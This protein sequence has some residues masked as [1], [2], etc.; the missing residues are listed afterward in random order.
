MLSQESV[1]WS[2]SGGS[3][4][5]DCI[6][7]ILFYTFRRELGISLRDYLEPASV[8]LCWEFIDGLWRKWGDG[9]VKEAKEKLLGDDRCDTDSADGQCSWG[10]W[11][12]C[13]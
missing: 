6:F 10:R 7:G 1:Q 9:E 3:E 4:E 5:Y 12:W 8:S 11:K 2:R 13:S